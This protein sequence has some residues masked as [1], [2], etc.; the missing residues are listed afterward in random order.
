MGQR[1]LW[2]AEL[3]RGLEEVA[4]HSEPQVPCK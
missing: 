4:V 3:L 2:P 1:T